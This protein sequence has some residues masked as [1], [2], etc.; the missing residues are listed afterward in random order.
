MQFFGMICWGDALFH[1][2]KSGNWECY[3]QGNSKSILNFISCK[4]FLCCSQPA[5]ILSIAAT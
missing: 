2:K 3:D 1:N 5:D 4:Q